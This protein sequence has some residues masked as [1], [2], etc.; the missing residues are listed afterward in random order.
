M[1]PKQLHQRGRLTNLRRQPNKKR[2]HYGRLF[3]TQ[4]KYVLHINNLGDKKLEAHPRLLFC[5]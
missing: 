1:K 2:V 3:Q 5:K 4:N